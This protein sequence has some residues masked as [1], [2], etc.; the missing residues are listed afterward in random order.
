M[1]S[2]RAFFLKHRMCYRL[3]LSPRTLYQPFPFYRRTMRQFTPQADGC[4]SS[5]RLFLLVYRSA[6]YFC[7]HQ[8]HRPSR[9]PSLG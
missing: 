9:I 2:Y 5:F 6:L 1:L 4:A 7:W 3:P 8:V